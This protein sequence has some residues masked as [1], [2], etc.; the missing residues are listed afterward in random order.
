MEPKATEYFR[1]FFETSHTILSSRDLHDILKLLVKRTVQALGVKA[2]SLMLVNDE[3]NR[4]ELVASHLLSRKYLAKGPLSADRSIPEVLEGK[5]VVIRNAPEDPRIQY[6][7]EMREEGIDTVLS[8]PVAARGQVIGVLRLY[9]REPRDFSP[10]ELEFV[11]ALA[12]MGG[13]AIANARIYE[14]EGVRLSSLLKEVGVD[15]PRDT[16]K[17][18]R[19]FKPFGFRPVDLSKSLDYFRALHQVTTAILSTLDSREVVELII[20]KVREMTGVEGCCLRLLRE[21][22]GELELVAAKG[23]SERYLKKG[24]LHA[25][26]SIRETLEG[27]PVLIADAASDPRIEYPA[28][29]A[30]EGIRSLLS[31]PIIARERVIGALRLYSREPRDYGEEEV[32][33]LSALAEI[34][35]IAIMNAKL[36]ERT[37]YDLSFWKATLDYLEA[38]QPGDRGAEDR[39]PE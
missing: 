17:A 19:R 5:T 25:D 39:R 29:I 20:D 23:L 35:G 16:R 24:P 1:I 13:L 26:R 6:R 12:E 3:T 7:S 37:Q 14:Q 38:E 21:P 31:V 8:V 33:F 27:E 30:E 10:E 28:A 11:A 2:G 22:T 18:K 32:A 34:A 15:L 9:T 36:Y 4:L